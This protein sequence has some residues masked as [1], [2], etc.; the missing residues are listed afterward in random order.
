MRSLWLIAVTTIVA[1]YTAALAHAQPAPLEALDGLDPVLLVQGKEVAGKPDVT[2]VRGRFEYAFSSAQ[3]KAA[4]ENAPE[5]FEIQL[6]GVCARM[7]PMAGGNPS[8]YVVHDGRIYIFGS[9][10]CHKRFVAAPAKF[11]PPVPAAMPGSARASADGRA[12]VD[13][14]VAAI[15]GAARL[16]ALTSYVESWSYTQDTVQGEVPVAARALWRFPTGVRME[17]TVKRPDRTQTTA[18]VMTGD[19]AWFDGGPNRIYP[20]RPDARAELERTYGQHLVPL[21]RSRA[22]PALEAAALGP[23]TIA[24]LAVERVRLRRGPVDVTLGIDSSSGEVRAIAFIGRNSEGEFG[25]Y[26]V[27]VSDYRAVDGLRL[28]F[29]ERAL[30]NGAP[31]PSLTR[32]LDAITLDVALDDAL[33]T[34]ADG[35]PL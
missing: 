35:P 7:G 30:F 22:S 10:D 1:G 15:G 26:E 9:D 16:G 5:Q 23:A 14:A 32:T 34:H 27:V 3:T 12:L 11:L 31:D 21:L 17:R 8:D 29:S 6:N 19:R 33:F 13:R 25:G 20:M 18:T 28:P 24:G 2:V 4:F